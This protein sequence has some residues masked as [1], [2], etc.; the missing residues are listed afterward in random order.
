MTGLRI[1]K[2]LKKLA[3]TMLVIVVALSS[4]QQTLAS[5]WSWSY[6]GVAKTTDL[7]AEKVEKAISSLQ[8]LANSNTKKTNTIFVFDNGALA[9]SFFESLSPILLFYVSDNLYSLISKPSSPYSEVKFEL[10]FS[11]KA[12]PTELMAKYNEMK[13]KIDAIV[14]AAPDDYGAKLKYFAD[15][16][17]D[18]AS[19]DHA[20]SSSSHCAEGFFYGGKIVCQGYSDMFYTLC[21]YAG[22]ECCNVSCTLNGVPHMFNAVKVDGVWKRID[23]TGIDNGDNFRNYAYFL[24]DLSEEWQNQLNQDTYYIT[25]Y[26]Q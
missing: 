3:S 23:V 18:N 11:D 12:N 7:Q 4:A 10:E 2:K 15:Y 22:I 26:V 6:T 9:R 19:Y 21:Y 13:P 25:D 24:T 1:E 16:I 14:A 17:C 8:E 20:E 5:T